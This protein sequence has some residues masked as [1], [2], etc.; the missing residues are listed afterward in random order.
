MPVRCFYL[1]D[2]GVWDVALRVP[3]WPSHIHISLSFYRPSIFTYSFSLLL[4]LSAPLHSLIPSPWARV[5]IYYMSVEITVFWIW[6]DNNWRP[7]KF[8]PWQWCFMS[9]FGSSWTMTCSEAGWCNLGQVWRSVWEIAALFIWQAMWAGPG[10]PAFAQHQPNLQW[11][12]NM[13]MQDA[14]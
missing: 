3:A 8:F 11:H 10:A 5:W 4:S 7:L 6:P 12:L 14:N 9:I 1:S 2:I 13:S